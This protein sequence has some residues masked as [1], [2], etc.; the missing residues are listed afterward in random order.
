MSAQQDH[1]NGVYIE[2]TMDEEGN[3]AFSGGWDF[4]DDVDEDYVGY[5]QTLLSGLYAILSTQHDNVI[6]A[7]QMAQVGASMRGMQGQFGEEYDD[8][9]DDEI[10]I[11][12]EPDE[13]FLEAVQKAQEAEQAQDNIVDITKMKFNPRKHRKH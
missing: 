2:L 1:L 8:E 4:D 6:V 5:M 13:E 7:G 9:Y 10:E 11:V 3:L 12:F